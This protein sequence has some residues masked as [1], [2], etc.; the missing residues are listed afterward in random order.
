MRLILETR[1][2]SMRLIWS[3]QCQEPREKHAALLLCLVSLLS[4]PLTA[5]LAFCG[6]DLPPPPGQSQPFNVA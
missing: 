4:R 2:R 6:T 5:L 1:V 3:Y